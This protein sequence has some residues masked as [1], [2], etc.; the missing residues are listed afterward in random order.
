MKT[1]QKLIAS[2]TA[3][4][5]LA[6]CG[7]KP[8]RMG[9]IEQPAQQ[10]SAEASAPSSV[11]A[12]DRPEGEAKAPASTAKDDAPAEKSPTGSGG[13]KALAAVAGCVLLAPV[14]LAMGAVA[15]AGTVAKAAAA[16]VV[17]VGVVAPLKAGKAVVDGIKGVVKSD[18]VETSP[19]QETDNMK[20]PQDSGTRQL[21]REQ[22][23]VEGSI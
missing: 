5:F 10:A 1:R 19:S 18:K 16:G 7:S 2:L 23:Q 20:A 14:C 9:A 17:Y 6:G 21:V 3:A 13:G 12:S 4:V 8:P 15:V 22:V 11:P